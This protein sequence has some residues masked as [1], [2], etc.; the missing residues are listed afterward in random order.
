MDLA[1]ELQVAVTTAGPGA[2]A[3]GSATTP[4]A[5]KQATRADSQSVKY[6]A[7]LDVPVGVHVTQRTS[8][9]I[10]TWN[11]SRSVVDVALM[12]TLGGRRC[13]TTRSGFCSPW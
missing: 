13:S 3:C 10:Q 5:S 7:L 4:I 1:A 9:G 11:R 6:L 8:T 12:V 2:L